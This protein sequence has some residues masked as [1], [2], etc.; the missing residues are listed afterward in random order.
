MG[1]CCLAF[2]TMCVHVHIVQRCV[3]DAVDGTAVMMTIVS[4]HSRTLSLMMYSSHHTHACTASQT[5]LPEA[6][7]S[8]DEVP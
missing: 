4:E 2:P 5:H 1:C 7:A 3:C 8:D 6:A